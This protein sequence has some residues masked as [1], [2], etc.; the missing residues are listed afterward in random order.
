MAG[1]HAAHAGQADAGSRVVTGLVQALE[2]AEQLAS[3]GH[4]KACTI[5]ADR[6]LMAAFGLL[7]AVHADPC[8]LAVA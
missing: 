3:I 1:Q 4:V 2:H 7:L 6:E 8:R 5:V